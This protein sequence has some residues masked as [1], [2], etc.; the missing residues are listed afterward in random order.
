MY[1]FLIAIIFV[2]ISSI[3]YASQQDTEMIDTLCQNESTILKYIKLLSKD[4]TDTKSVKE[5]IAE[6]IKI[7]ECIEFQAME[8][9]VDERR[10][11]LGPFY[12]PPDKSVMYEPIRIRKF[13]GI[14]TIK[15]F[16]T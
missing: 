11:Q 1:K 8:L 13:W 15:M 5:S 6:D 14:H 9:P 16:T 7:G 2:F 4:P 10:E 3:S 12:V